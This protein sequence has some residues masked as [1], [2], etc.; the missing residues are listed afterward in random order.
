MHVHP[1]GQA[2]LETG[3]FFT[4][5]ANRFDSDMPPIHTQSVADGDVFALGDGQVE[6]VELPGHSLDG[7]GY[8]IPNQEM[9]ILGTLLPRADRPTRWDLPGG[10]LPDVIAS[11]KRVLRM[12]AKSVIPLQGP[13]IKGK[14]HVKEVLKRH[15]DFFETCLTNEGKVSKSV[16]KPAQTA[17]WYTPHPPWPLE[18]QERS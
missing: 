10:C 13:A 14:K 1:Q 5:W 7:M 3:D 4:T 2:A 17:L 18:E 11:L 12:N 15:I 9:M 16:P 8:W 6:S